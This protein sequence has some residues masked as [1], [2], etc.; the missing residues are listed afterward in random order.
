[1]AIAIGG[2]VAGVA[3]LLLACIELGWDIPLQIAEGLVGAKAQHGGAAMYALGVFLHFFIA[4][5]AASVYYAASRKLPFMTEYPLVCGLLFRRDGE[6]GD[7][8]DRIPAVRISCDRSVADRWP[9]LRAI[10]E[11]DH[12]RATDFLQCVVVCEASSRIQM[13]RSTRGIREDME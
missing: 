10:A 5:S 4:F 2:G 1:L 3:D 13:A 12:R 11:N 7:A 8:P 9:D 6:A